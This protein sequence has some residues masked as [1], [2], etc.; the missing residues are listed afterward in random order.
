MV[1][2]VLIFADG[3]R[4]AWPTDDA[5]ARPFVHAGPHSAWRTGRRQRLGTQL[6]ARNIRRSHQAIGQRTSVVTSPR[7]RV[8]DARRGG[9]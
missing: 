3:D 1:R 2:L 5:H 8:G 9:P 7:S 4:V 6:R